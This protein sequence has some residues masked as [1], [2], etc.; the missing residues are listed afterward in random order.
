VRLTAT[1]A[2]ERLDRA[3]RRLSLFAKL[4]HGAGDATGDDG[5]VV[6]TD[7]GKIVIVETQRALTRSDRL[8]LGECL[9]NLR[10]DIRAARAAR[11]R[12]LDV[13]RSAPPNP[14]V[15]ARLQALCSP[16]GDGPPEGRHEL[17]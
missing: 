2:D 10:D 8:A 1:Q 6:E 9:E 12:H 17:V 4:L 16:K 13:R 3:A 5:E 15:V 11:T 7:D 14:E